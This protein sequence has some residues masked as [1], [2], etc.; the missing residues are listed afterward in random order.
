MAS[1][2]VPLRIAYL[3]N[4]YP[5][6]SHTFIRREIAALEDLGADVV[7]FSVRRAADGVVDPDDLRERARTQVLLDADLAAWARALRRAV[8]EQPRGLWRAARTAAAWGFG[9]DRGRWQHAAYLAEACLLADGLARARVT[10]VHAHF[11]TNPAAVVVLARLLGGPPCSFTVHGPE[12]FDRPEAL[13]LRSKI[14]ASRFVVAIS[15]FAR[16]QLWRQLPPTEWSKVHVVRCGLDG[17]A[18]E[19]VPEPVPDVP[20]LC[21]VGRLDPQKGHA[22]LLEAVGR[23]VADGVPVE[24]VLVGD[25]PMRGVLE[26][27]IATQGLAEHVSITGWAT[28]AQVRR[29]LAS[30]RAMVLPSF[31]EGLPVVIMEALALGRPVVS[32]SIAG[33]PEL[34][35]PGESGWLVPAGSVE[36]LG[37]ALRACLSADVGTLTRMGRAGRAKVRAQH[38]VR[39]SAAQLFDL[40]AGEPMPVVDA[41]TLATAAE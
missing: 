7:R 5:A 13:S 32:T 12:E 39:R 30:S 24:L 16:S 23:L 20:R 1:P 33:I 4:Q 8:L 19:A 15:S 25:G 29:E 3:V 26:G 17:A 11:G 22:L 21:C 9:S 18:L 31:A 27:I 41:R 35:V 14:D 2:E 38:D 37:E 6:I 40:I 36:A 34:V 10:H 28:G